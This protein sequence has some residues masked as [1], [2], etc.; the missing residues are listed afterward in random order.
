MPHGMC[1]LWDPKMLILQI[2]SDAVTALAYFSIP[3]LLLYF[4]SKRRDVPFSG[5]IAMFGLFIVACGLTHVMSIYTIWHPVYWLD[6]ALKAFAAIVSLATAIMLVP[7]VPKALMLRTPAALERL[8]ESLER[9][10][11][12]RQQAHAETERQYRSLAE[13]LPHLVWTAQADG[14]LDYGNGRWLEYTGMQYEEMLAWA[15]SSIVH[16]ADIATCTAAWKRALDAKSP[17]EVEYRLRRTDGAYRWHIGRAQPIFDASREVGRWFGTCTDI[18]DQKHAF[19][20]A[21]RLEEQVRLNAV[22]KDDIAARTRAET[23][24]RASDERFRRVEENAPIGLALVDLDGFFI[25]VNPALCA[26]VGST[27]EDLLNRSFQSLMHPDDIVVTDAKDAI[28]MIDDSFAKQQSERR[29]IHADGHVVWTLLNVSTVRDEDGAPCYFIAQIQDITSRI[30]AEFKILSAQRAVQAAAEAKARFLATMSHEIRTPMNGIIGMAELL[31]LSNL[32]EDQSECIRVVRDSGRS[33][34]RVLNDILDYSKIEAGKLTFSVADFDLRAQIR[35]IE[36]LLGPQFAEKHVALAIDIDE[37]VGTEFAG[38]SG[39]I[40]QILINLIANALKFTPPLGSVRVTIA[41]DAGATGAGALRFA[42]TDTGVGIEPALQ[43]RLFQPFSQID[44]ST[45]REYGGTGL[46][47]S[48]CKELVHLMGGE[49]GV[50]ST[51]GV[52]SSFWFTLPTLPSSQADAPPEAARVPIEPARARPERVLLAED[53]EINTRVAVRQF[54]RLG[55]EVTDGFERAR[56]RRCGRERGVRHHLHGLSHAGDGRLRRDAR[57]S[58]SS[59]ATAA[60]R[61]DRRDDGERAGG[62]SR[63]ML[64]GRHGRLHLEAGNA[65]RSHARH[66]TMAAEGAASGRL[67]SVDATSRSRAGTPARTRRLVDIVNVRHADRDDDESDG[68]RRLPRIRLHAGRRRTAACGDVLHRRRRRR[69]PF[70]RPGAVRTRGA[71]KAHDR[72]H[73]LPRIP[74]NDRHVWELAMIRLVRTPAFVVFPSTVVSV[75]S[76]TARGRMR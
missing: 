44:A 69:F 48:I 58:R 72:R 7:L 13:A 67:A 45:T 39:R 57:H 23:A 59:G 54:S 22:L 60:P 74:C 55:F 21:G 10:L 66:R 4:L 35:S 71:R 30:D 15:W 63:R 27:K 37:A 1:Y 12:T 29:Y 8:N 26:L 25:R 73:V 65:R 31:A 34:L 56:G 52:G 9:D 75:A 24:L 5:T 70:A 18:D 43:D 19:E 61:P 62:R 2:G 51:P 68:R 16:P 76:A 3:I 32:T 50:E 41:A 49:I 28:T 17:F 46:G 20:A 64:R 40:R 47:L 38:D 14:S 42:V 36:S 53:N 6:G 33:L 11:A